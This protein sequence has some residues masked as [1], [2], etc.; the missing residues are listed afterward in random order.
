MHVPIRLWP[1][2]LVLSACST[3]LACRK[4]PGPSDCQRVAVVLLG[5]ENR[6]MLADPRVKAQ[7]DQVTRDCLLTPFDKAFVRCLDETEQSQ[8]CLFEFKRRRESSERVV[9]EEGRE[10]DGSVRRW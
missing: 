4:L 8:K 6:S 1:Y 7:F 3:L 5:I 10:L 2:A 9:S